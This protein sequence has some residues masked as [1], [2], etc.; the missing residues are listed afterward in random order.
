MNEDYAFHKVLLMHDVWEDVEKEE[1]EE[2]KTHILYEVEDLLREEEPFPFQDEVIL[3]GDFPEIQW[4]WNEDYLAL[5]V[6]KLEFVSF[7]VEHH[8][9]WID[10]QREE[11]EEYFSSIRMNEEAWISYKLYEAKEENLWIPPFRIRNPKGVKPKKL[12]EEELLARAYTNHDDD[13]LGRYI[14]RNGS[15]PLIIC[16][17]VHY[18]ERNHDTSI[19]SYILPYCYNY[20]MIKMALYCIDILFKTPQP[21]QTFK[22]GLQGWYHSLLC[23]E[24]LLFYYA[25]D[26]AGSILTHP[27]SYY[28]FDEEWDWYYRRDTM[29]LKNG[30]RYR[31]EKKQI[32]FALNE[33]CKEQF[34]GQAKALSQVSLFGNLPY[35]CVDLQ[36]RILAFVDEKY[37][38]PA[39]AFEHPAWKYDD[40]FEEDIN[41]GLLLEYSFEE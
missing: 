12:S 6:L 26:T 23:D 30:E 40:P 31:D 2:W 21:L 13:V 28:D 4:W 8:S 36:R 39:S 33:K 14:E 3:R 24:H 37:Y 27:Y 41:D 32:I 17:P 16:G 25:V 18:N 19:A 11:E 35:L 5:H 10:V 22:T 38:L 7:E 34:L 20:G 9:V 29:L 15:L 1:I